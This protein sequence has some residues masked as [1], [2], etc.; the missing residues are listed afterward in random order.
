MNQPN[1]NL[2]INGVGK[3]T[4][5][6]YDNVFIDGMGT[7]NGDVTCGDMSCNGTIKVHGQI[8]AQ[9]LT[10]NGTGSLNGALE[11]DTLRADGMLS[12]TGEIRLDSLTMNGIAK[13]DASLNGETV[14]INGSLKTKGDLQCES[15]DVRGNLQVGGLLNAGTIFIELFG[16]CRAREIG[17]ER[18]IVRRRTEGK[19]LLQLFSIV[20]ATKLT[21]DVVEGD[22]IELENTKAKIVRGSRVRIGPG[23]EIDRVE[24]TETYDADLKSDIS[25]AVKM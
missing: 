13:T 22:D 14:E 10:I 9:S 20:P 21:V 18:I 17:G 24:Y 19:S 11:C 3:A 8:K 4:G 7:I 6:S 5:G 12:V 25:Y 15:L 16:G 1:R 2:R 23:C